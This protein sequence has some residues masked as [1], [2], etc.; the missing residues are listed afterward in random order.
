LQEENAKLK[1]REDG[2]RFKP[3][4]TAD[5]IATVLVGMF[6]ARKAEAIARAVLTMLKARKAAR[7]KP[8]DVGSMS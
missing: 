4:D 6:S 3:T 8:A 5:D 2:D 7:N 1:Q